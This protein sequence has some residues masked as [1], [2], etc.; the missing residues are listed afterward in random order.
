MN[1][2]KKSLGQ[3]APPWRI[4]VS[5]PAIPTLARFHPFIIIVFFLLMTTLS[6]TQVLY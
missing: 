2:S 4:P 5:P 1:S 3:S 6:R